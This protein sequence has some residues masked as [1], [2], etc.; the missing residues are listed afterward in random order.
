MLSLG[1][2]IAISI[3]YNQNDEVSRAIYEYNR[4]KDR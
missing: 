3:V 1:I 2:V 4:K